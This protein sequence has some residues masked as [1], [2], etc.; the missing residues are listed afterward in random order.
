M[1]K[2]GKVVLVIAIVGACCIAGVTLLLILAA[3]AIPAMQATIR[4]ANETSATNVLKLINTQEQAYAMT[5]PQNGFACSLTALAGSTQSGPATPEAAQLIPPELTTGHKAGYTFYFSDCMKEKDHT[6]SYKLTAIPD[7]VG[8]TGAR[9]F[10][11]DQDGA[12]YFDP[13]GG[14]NCT[15]VLQ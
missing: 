14:T 15:E 5:Y 12:I 7:V 2:Q 3:L 8:H 11:T 13:K 9:G 6:I 4:K 10:C 1:T